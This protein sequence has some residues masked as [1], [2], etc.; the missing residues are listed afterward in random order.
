MWKYACR[1]SALHVRLDAPLPREL[2]VGEGT[3]LFVGGWCVAPAGRIESLTY[4]VDGA[5]QPVME[6]GMPR[7]DVFRALHPGLDPFETRGIDSDP[8]SPDDPHM[9]SYRSGFWGI[10]RVEPKQGRDRITIAL[11]G[12][13]EDGTTVEAELAQIDEV[14]LEP[15][16][17]NGHLPTA[18]APLVAIALA[19]YNP[20]AE[21]LRAQLDSIRAQT[22]GN[23]VCV[24]SDDCSDPEHFAELE[25]Q[26][27]GDP[28]FVVSRSPR[29]LG[30]Y[31]N[32]ERALALAPE[33]A[34]F[35]AMSD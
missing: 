23:W 22:H 13:L 6:H 12:R 33:D 3:A 8:D 10:V 32:F 26:V 5:E 31:R 30:F 1:I 28:R 11:R 19:T 15:P 29:R 18:G 24:I 9:A 35:V 4:V 25:E 20:P 34:D 27:N 17:A 2:A 14:P 21:L 16:T 7:L